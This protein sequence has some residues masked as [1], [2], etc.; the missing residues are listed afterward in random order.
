MIGITEP[1]RGT[2]HEVKKRTGI[3]LSASTRH[4]PSFCVPQMC[5]HHQTTPYKTAKRLHVHS[6]HLAFESSSRLHSPQTHSQH[7]GHRWTL[8]D[9]SAAPPSPLFFFFL[10]LFVSSHPLTYQSSSLAPH[11]MQSVSSG[12]RVH[13]FSGCSHLRNLLQRRSSWISASRVKRVEVG[14]SPK[15]MPSCELSCGQA[16][17]SH[18]LPQR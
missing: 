1:Q 6:S 16:H 12:S 15:K 8:S 13:L 2:F 9:K 10:F 4:T 7:S 14:I 17:E 11:S 5:H 18:F 3:R